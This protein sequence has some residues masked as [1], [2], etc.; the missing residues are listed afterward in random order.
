MRKKI[1]LLLLSITCVS[2]LYASGGWATCAICISKNGGSSYSYPIYLE[3]G[4][5]DGDW[6]LNTNLDGMNFGTPTSLVLNGAYG[7]GWSDDYPGYNSTSFTLYYRVYKLN[8]T[9]GSWTQIALDNQYY[10][11]G[12]NFLYSKT[13]SN[14]D[15]LALATEKGTNT[16]VLEVAMSKIQYYTGGSWKS[17]IPGGQTIAYTSS[18]SGYKATFIKTIATDLKQ[19]VQNFTVTENQ[20]KIH[21]SFAGTAN[22]ELYNMS[23]QL[24]DKQTAQNSYTHILKRGAYLMRFNGATQKIIVH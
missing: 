7:N 22:I 9:P 18:N 17:M 3:A 8:A 15:I 24:I 14:V 20:G 4:W 10:Q 1:T 6:T 11:I 16:Y 19:P 23:G 2:M 5:T 12:N 21:A 13:S